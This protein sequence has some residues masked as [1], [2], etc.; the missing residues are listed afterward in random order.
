LQEI[1]GIFRSVIEVEA[2]AYWCFERFILKFQ[3]HTLAVEV[4]QVAVWT[5]VQD[6]ELWKHLTMHGTDIK[7]VVARWFVSLYT[8][9]LPVSA[10]ERYEL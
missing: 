1:A 5:E 3:Q 6:P 9:S 7:A 10:I 4:K 2:D 8:T